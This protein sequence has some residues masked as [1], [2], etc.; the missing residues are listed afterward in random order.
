MRGVSVTH[1]DHDRLGGGTRLAADSLAGLD[2]FHAPGDAAEHNV[3]AVEP[4]G[5]DSAEEELGAVGAGPSVGHGQNT[6]ACGG[7]RT[8]ERKQLFL[9]DSTGMAAP[10]QCA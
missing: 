4:V 2:D 5:L 9:R 1:R 10:H 7:R 8:T 3:L 6:R